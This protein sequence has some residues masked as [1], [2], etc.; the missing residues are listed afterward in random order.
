MRFRDTMALILTSAGLAGC[1]SGP[2]TP[3]IAEN[4]VYGYA[5]V[6]PACDAP[7]VLSTIRSRFA[8]KE[9]EYWKSPLT[10]ERIEHVRQIAFRPWSKSFIP[11]R[12]CTASTT[13][14]DHKRRRIDYSIGEDLGIIGATWGVTW[15]VTGTD[16]NLAF[17]P[18]CK[19][20][21]P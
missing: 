11:R 3:L 21:R 20:A 12:Y 5:A 8:A 13:T 17:A 14:S 4:R 10:L 19:M 7:A 16:R 1:A 18:D 2:P 15:C 6:I 9:S